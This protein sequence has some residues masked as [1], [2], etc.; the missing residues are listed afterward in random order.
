MFKRSQVFSPIAINDIQL[1]LLL[2]M[3]LCQSV[4][5]PCFFIH[6]THRNT[7]SWHHLLLTHQYSCVTNC[8]WQTLSVTL[9]L[10][11]AISPLSPLSSVNWPSLL[12]WVSLHVKW[13][14]AD[15]VKNAAALSKLPPPLPLTGEVKNSD[16]HAKSARFRMF[17]YAALVFSVLLERR[18]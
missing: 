15:T 5:P 7:S 11:I 4:S 6:T 17:R 10:P 1:S 2:S 12:S 3:F 9:L 14:A 18:V 8:H 13:A 16:R